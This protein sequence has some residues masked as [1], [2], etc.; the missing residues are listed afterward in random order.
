MTPQNIILSRTD[1]IGDVVLALPMAGLLKQHFPA[2]NISLLGRAYTRAVAECCQHIDTFLDWSEVEGEAPRVQSEFL[3]ASGADA[4][5]HV[6]PRKQIA[7]AARKARI[8][9]R[10][11]HGRRVWGFL[12]SNRRVYFSASS[13]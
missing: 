8:S 11:G 13:V 1:H 7:V 5:V 12:N 2:S 10:V 4:I 3:R 9:V 6:Y